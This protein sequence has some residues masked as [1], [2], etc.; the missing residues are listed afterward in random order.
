MLQP[1]ENKHETT[2]TTLSD[3]ND[4]DGHTF[5]QTQRC[6]PTDTDT[7]KD[8]QIETLTETDTNRHAKKRA[9]LPADYSVNPDHS[10]YKRGRPDSKGGDIS[11]QTNTLEQSGASKHD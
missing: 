3:E 5:T 8:T 2:T 1:A 4:P 6:R 9:D 7:D 11:I 10:K